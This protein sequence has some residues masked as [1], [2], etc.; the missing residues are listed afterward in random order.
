MTS[1]LGRCLEFEY[2]HEAPE[3]GD[4]DLRGRRARAARS[5]QAGHPGHQ[6]LL[7]TLLRCKPATIAV[8]Y[9]TF[10]QPHV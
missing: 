10:F 8:T 5:A 9:R 1:F 4:R 3:A 7:R 2:V 6:Q